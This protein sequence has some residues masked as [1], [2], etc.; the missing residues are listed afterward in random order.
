MVPVKSKQY[1]STKIRDAVF[2]IF[3]VLILTGILTGTF[4]AAAADGTP[5]ET[6]IVNRA[7][8]MYEDAEGNSYE[9]V[10]ETV[11]VTVVAV[12]AISVTPDETDPSQIIAPNE[13]V[14]RLFRICNTGNTTDTF[15]PTDA[16]I[17]APATITQTYFDSDNSGT[18]TAADAPITIGQTLSPKLIR[19][20]CIGVLYDILTN[21]L[22]PQSRVIIG[23]TARTSQT[24]PGS[25]TFASDE[26][27]IINTVGNGSILT[28]P[29]SPDL[30]P[31]KLV[32]DSARY[33]AAPGQ[34]LNYKI[35]FRNR[36]SV[37]AR[38]VR[39]TDDL[40][41]ELEY[42]PQTLRLN[43]RLLTD[44]ADGDEGTASARRLELQI[45]SIAPD[46][47]TLIEFK[48][49]LTGNASNG[50]GV[51]NFA[52]LSAQ[53][54]PSVRSTE[55]VVVINP[56]G[57]VYAG[58]SGGSVRIGG[59]RV[60]VATDQTGT[61]VGLSPKLGFDI[62]PANANPFITNGNGEF[63][64]AL[65][66]DQTGG[67][68]APAIYYMHA[69][70]P[71]YRA[72]LLEVGIQPG[73][74]G[75]SFYQATIRAL[76]G[77]AVATAGGFAL[78]EQTVIIENLAA[79][80]F[81]IP[82][83][84]LTT[85]EISKSADKSGAQIGDIVTYR[86]QLRNATAAPIDSV[87]VRDTLPSTFIYI[88]GTA[89][90]ESGG[91][92]EEITP[93]VNGNNLTFNLGTLAAGANVTISYRV[94]IG[95][96]APEGTHYNS[97]LAT[98]TQMDGSE[99]RT[100]RVRAPVRVRGGVFSMRQVIIGRVYEDRN[101]NGKFDRGER[102][103]SGARIYSNNG[104]SVITDS[105]GLYNFPA[106]DSGSI[107]LSLDPITLPHGYN[108]LDDDDRR[109]SKGWT[110]LLRT[111]LGG[112]SLLRQNFAIAPQ[113]E[114]LAVSD[115]ARVITAQ[116]AFV[117]PVERPTNETPVQTAELNKKVEFNP[118]ASARSETAASETY[119]VRTEE[120]V[121]PI[122][123]GDIRVVYPETGTLVMSPA[124]AIVARVTNQWMIEA[125]INGA[126]ISQTN[127]GETRVD[128]RNRITTYTFVGIS[129]VPG[130][131]TVKLT[132]VDEN[133]TRGKSV[134]FRVIGRGSAVR[135]EISPAKTS[136]SGDGREALP[137]EIRAF[138]RL[139]N[140]ALD[141]QIGVQTSAG[142]FY[143]PQVNPEAGATD[144]LQ[145]P[146]QQ[147]ISLE[148]GR[149]IVYLLGAGS[150]D[151]ARVKAVSGNIEA[152]TDVRFTAELRPT[153]LVGVAELAIGRAAPE[154]SN[155]GTDENIRGRVA[156][157]YRGQVFGDNLLTL[158]YDSQRPLNRL[159]GRDRLGQIDPLEYTYPIF[160][161]TSEFFDG[162]QSNSKI[163]ARI[164]RGR[165]YA[166]FGDMEADMNQTALTGYNRRLTGVKI[167]LENDSGD[168]VSVTGSRPD[169]AFSRDVFPGGGLSL[170]RLAHGDILPGSEVISLEVRDR[171][172]PDIVL[173]RENLIRSIDYNLEPL[174]GEVFFLRPISAF[175][176][177]LNLL[178]IVATYEY[179]SAGASNYVYTGRAVRNFQRFGMRLGASFVNQQ[180]GEIGA[181]QLGGIDAEKTLWNGGRMTLEAALSSGRFAG[182]VN[183]FDFYNND[184]GGFSQSNDA[185]RSHNGMAF[186]VK[187]DQPLPFWNSRLR[188]DFAR[189][190][191]G[192]YNPF[193][194]TVTSGAQ[195]FGLTYEVKPRAGRN[196]LFGYL[197]ERNK[198]DNVNNSRTTFSAL[199]SEQW[200]DKLRTALGFDHREFNDNIG[201]TSISSNLI[202]AGIE[203]R[204]TER[205]E[206]SAKREQNLTD[207]D[208]TYPDQTT[209]S[210]K[211]K[212]NPNAHL[213]VT[214]RLAGSP[215]TPIGDYSGSGFASVGTRNETSFGIETKLPYI[216]ALTG[217]YQIENGVTGLDNFAV[218][219]LQNSWKLT[220][221]LA[222]ETGFERGFLLSGESQN[223]NNAT[224][225]AAW[226][227]ADGFRANAR[228]ELRDRNGLGQLFAIG[229]AG[230]VGD[231]W[232]TLARAQWA[233]S[234][235][236]NRRGT[237][238]GAQAAIAYRPIDTDK[239][240]ILFS[241]THRQAFQQGFVLNGVEQS[242][243]RDRIDRLSADGLYQVNSGL[244]LY[245]RFALSF[246]GNG[247]NTTAYSSAFTYLMQMRA[248]QRLNNFLDVSAET[249]W[250]GQSGS[251][252]F[253]RS[254]GTEIGFWVLPDIRV[255]SGYNFVQVGR[256][257]AGPDFSGSAN[258][259][260]GFYFTLTTKLSNLFDLFGTSSTGL[261]NSPAQENTEPNRRIADNQTTR[262][263]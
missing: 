212:L 136:V 59:A 32:E 138:D 216:G 10:S 2:R 56:V 16:R 161:D 140:P 131:N 181:F 17:S 262:P 206:I 141:S 144:P 151:T 247:N 197:N 164:D 125:E 119:T 55:A 198:T 199:W 40:P 165:S 93:E 75:N 100:S 249:R 243:T 124:L 74:A 191:P 103:V 160:G 77:Q 231:N 19:G 236:N 166:M 48:A 256:A 41:A 123:P 116:G 210:I 28:S 159:A 241:Y 34:T 120:D 155:S 11:R 35:A 218:I 202:T 29:D 39:I 143:A 204:P 127:I 215:I 145:F 225:G 47:L 147:A 118:S 13:R 38:V 12:P 82:M 235:F 134:E 51:V 239:Y 220:N 72:R 250:L 89:Q 22:T 6:I 25:G 45:P 4:S 62:N 70:A 101:R 14:T 81:N 42:V 137:I 3:V 259:R 57:V 64:F 219:G 78:T 189:A 111:P 5:A 49:R 223:F 122:S 33:T 9:T 175:D 73:N 213:F 211:Y 183:V 18:I 92:I 232:T 50:N 107:V 149:A 88:D 222:L 150:A 61:P 21:G 36:G 158:A 85:L 20:A 172:N 152:Q 15:L 258:F 251:N 113:N 30:P 154:I 95:A 112:G 105:A 99:I 84:E 65:G 26:G 87:I 86:V 196:L 227:P 46:A 7:N 24:L 110:R 168:F 170:V 177:Q 44:A 71:N 246:N 182:G 263:E 194:T 174:T 117:P 76:D 146:Q 27:T 90:L 185:S 114:S 169:T 31:V 180:Q 253:R 257:H 173:S 37:A 188:A 108:L 91:F 83:F 184:N 121:E 252:T 238:S 245:G 96:D 221:T 217:R 200:S 234:N 208:P 67:T 261:E 69:T 226:T 66:S 8:A 94:R 148:N 132:A 201:D 102:P 214:Q 104:Q 157:Y 248:Q 128:N 58:N 60:T 187:L 254:F 139:G 126:K 203:Y 135:L 233:L 193:G 54:A 163:Y 133:G 98:G 162:A 52:D 53:N 228:Y 179:F 207:A 224:L 171:R 156:L 106:V 43:T 167:H 115:E 63:S 209:F 79:L 195:R 23:L 130:I 97:A 237:S 229:A 109:S 153:L 1:R 142:K 68:G 176:Y 240:A 255:G 260:R 205:I 230:K 244:E 192:F 190:N 242:E 80:V 129:L 178:Q 186:A